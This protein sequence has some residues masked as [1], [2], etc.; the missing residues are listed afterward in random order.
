FHESSGGIGSGSPPSADIRR[1]PSGVRYTRCRESPSQVGESGKSAAIAVGGPVGPPF[2]PTG[3]TIS[4][5]SLTYAI[6]DPSG[7][8]TG[9]AFSRFPAE[10]PTASVIAAR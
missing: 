9:P 8:Q 1:R 6:R 3:T 10:W 7:D 5:P 2:S 4:E